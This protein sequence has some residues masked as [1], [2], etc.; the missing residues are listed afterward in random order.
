MV[1]LLRVP[2]DKV[3]LADLLPEE[4]NAVVTQIKRT[5]EG[6]VVLLH[7]RGVT[8]MPSFGKIEV[9]RLAGRIIDHDAPELVYRAG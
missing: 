3:R 9:R 5:I 2:A 1:E 8:T 4:S 6:D 7:S